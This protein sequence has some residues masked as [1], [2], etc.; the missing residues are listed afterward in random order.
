M[1]YQEV[2]IAILPR[3]FTAEARYNRIFFTSSF[4]I[5]HQI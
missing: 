4:E 5:L 3:D 1:P 2:V